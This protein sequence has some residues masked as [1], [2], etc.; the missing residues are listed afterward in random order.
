MLAELQ[1]NN[2]RKELAGAERKA[3]AAEVGRLLAK[4]RENCKTPDD[5]SLQDGWLIQLAGNSAISQRAAYNWWSAFCRET[6]LSITPRQASDEHRNAFFAWLDAQ[7]QAEE[8]EK[9]RR[10]AEV[11]A[12]KERRD[13]EAYEQR[14]Q[15]EKRDFLRY[16]D[17]TVKDWGPAM[18][19][20]WITEW[21]DSHE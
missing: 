20:G 13:R 14:V 16:I 9:A 8:A 17:D 15:A 11:R 7:K 18:V 12:E 1:E 19:K 2:A 3:F 5:C 10:Q 6:G 21:L 4:L